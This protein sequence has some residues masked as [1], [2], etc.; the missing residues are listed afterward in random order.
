MVLYRNNELVAHP[1]RDSLK[2]LV[3][4]P[5]ALLLKL[6]HNTPVASGRSNEVSLGRCPGD[7]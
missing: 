3:D 6:L 7:E 1:H 4:R 5:S 2:M